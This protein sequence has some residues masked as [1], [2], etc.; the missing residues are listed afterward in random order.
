MTDPRLLG[1]TLALGDS[2]TKYA[3]PHGANTV[4]PAQ[5]FV[6]VHGTEGDIVDAASGQTVGAPQVTVDQ[7]RR[8]IEILVPHAAFD[9]AGEH[10]VRVALG[11][12]LW[13]TAGKSY[14]VPQ[15]TADATHPGGAIQGDPTPPT[16][17]S[18]S[19]PA[20]FATTA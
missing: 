5:R 4:M 10:A 18:P 17:I 15:A 3:A 2:A 9:P 1:L 11:A 16:S 12:G 7:T 14:L 19:W 8:Q 13:D 20:R 6:T